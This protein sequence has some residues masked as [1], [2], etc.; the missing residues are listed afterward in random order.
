MGQIETM[1]RA[2]ASDFARALNLHGE[3]DLT[4]I[5]AVD[6]HYDTARIAELIETSDPEDF[7]NPYLVTCCEFGALLGNVMKALQPRLFWCPDWPYWESSLI[8]PVSGNCIPVFHWAVKKMSADG[9]DDGFAEKVGAALEFLD[10]P[11]A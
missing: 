7:S 5:R 1:T 2:A 4:W 6:A 8:D 10:R 9:W 3:M 11:R